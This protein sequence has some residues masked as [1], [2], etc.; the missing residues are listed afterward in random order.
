M[1]ASILACRSHRNRFLHTCLQNANQG[2]RFATQSSPRVL[3]KLEFLDGNRIAC[4]T[5]NHPERRNAL[6]N[7]ML[8]ELENH[9]SLLKKEHEN[10]ILKT[11]W[12]FLIAN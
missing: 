10:G 9:I 7:A 6:S 4:L 8:S 11:I 2:L 12:N 3:T 1:Y 5:L